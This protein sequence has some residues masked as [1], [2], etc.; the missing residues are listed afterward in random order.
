M[1]KF[2]RGKNKKRWIQKAIKRPGAF[3]EYC[4]RKGYTGV[5]KECI[6][7]GKKSKDPTVRRRAILAE[8]LRKMRKRRKK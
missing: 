7:E 8:T 4:I 1:T 6:E 5:T 2:A 3:R